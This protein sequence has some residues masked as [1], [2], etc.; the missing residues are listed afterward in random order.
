MWNTSPLN[1]IPTQEAIPEEGGSKN[2]LPYKYKWQF[3]NYTN[4][5]K[6]DHCLAILRRWKQEK[7]AAISSNAYFVKP[8]AI[9]LRIH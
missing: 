8:K 6:V 2:R 4:Y 1:M 3:K 7:L 9:K 5:S